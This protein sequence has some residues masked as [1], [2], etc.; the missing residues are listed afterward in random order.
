MFLFVPNN[1]I[2]LAH[3]TVIIVLSINLCNVESVVVI[4]PKGEG[5]YYTLTSLSTL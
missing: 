1:F 5:G 2:F 4:E 3:L